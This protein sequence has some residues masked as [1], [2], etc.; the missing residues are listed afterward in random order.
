VDQDRARVKQPFGVG[1]ERLARAA[2]EAGAMLEPV[3][4]EAARRTAGDA[5]ERAS[6]LAA[7]ATEPGETVEEALLERR[8][9]ARV[10]EVGDRCG[11]G[12]VAV[13]ES[14]ESGA[15]RLLVAGELAHEDREQHV[16][17]ARR[18][19]RAAD[20]LE[21]EPAER[22]HDDAHRRAALRPREARRHVLAKAPRRD[23]DAH[24]PREVRREE[25]RRAA[26]VA[27]LADRRD[28]LGHLCDERRL[29]GPRSSVDA[30][31]SSHGK[32]G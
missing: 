10:E 28:E 12:G 32:A 18:L 6:A 26:E 11:D 21:R 15:E 19:A 4:G 7:R 8:L 5:R 20:D 27:R 24:R 17:A 29:G 23:D 1:L 22:L 3:V 31:A 30:D 13:V 25:R 2:E 9:V 16:P 14:L